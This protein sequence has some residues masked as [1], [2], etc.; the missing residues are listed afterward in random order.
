MVDAQCREMLTSV[1]F[2]ILLL[3]IPVKNIIVLVILLKICSDLFTVLFA[4]LTF[5]RLCT[6][7]SKFECSRNQMTT[8]TFQRI[9]DP[10]VCEPWRVHFL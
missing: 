7:V 8:A 3:C 2:N 4:K 9:E 5:N 10:L 1:R 6:I